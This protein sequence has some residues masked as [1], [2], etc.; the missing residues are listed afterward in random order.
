[1][2]RGHWS[3]ALYEKQTIF[4]INKVNTSEASQIDN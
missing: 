2:V 4:L 1:M 3:N